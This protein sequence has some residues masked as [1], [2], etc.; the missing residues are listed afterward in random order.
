MEIEKRALLLSGGGARAAYQVGVLK[1]L[2]EILPSTAHNPFPIICGTSAGA[3]NAA[4][5]ASH[6]GSFREAVHNL[7]LLWR[8]LSPDKVYKTSGASLFKSLARIGLSLFNQGSSEGKPLSLLDNSPLLDL[9]REAVDLD[10]LDG[11]IESGNLEALCI[12]AL[13]Y[14]SGESVNFFQGRPGLAF[15]RRYQRIG[16][17]C[18]LTYQHLLASSAIPTI[19]PSVKIHREYFGDGALR[20]IA[21]ISPALHLGANRLFIIGVSSNRNPIHWG[22][23]KAIRHTPS[24]A[25]IMGQMFNSAFIDALE[26]DI[27]HMERINELLSLIPDDVRE[28]EG[29]VLRQVNSLVISPSEEMDV[30]AGRKVRSLPPSLRLALRAVGATKKGGGATAASYLLFTSDYC[31]TLIDMGYKDAMWERNHI[32]EFFELDKIP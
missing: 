30:I 27:E 15:W 11:A 2:T 29:L 32:E 10:A 18:K 5:L 16:S 17:P 7:E 20:Q 22:K 25:Q 19:F 31:G 14:S 4:A 26:G 1:A 24:M 21:P 3:I 6:P 28:A 9:L 23:R 12:T 13:G 8:N